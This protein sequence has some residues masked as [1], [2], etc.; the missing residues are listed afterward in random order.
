MRRQKK[1]KTQENEIHEH[2]SW[3]TA[4]QTIRQATVEEHMLR[5]Q[6][7]WP[8]ADKETQDHHMTWLQKTL[9]VYNQFSET[10]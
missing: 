3:M 6:V 1:K 2:Q 5:S 9:S 4:S 7:A 10:T 8:R